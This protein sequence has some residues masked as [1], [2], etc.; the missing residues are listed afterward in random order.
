MLQRYLRKINMGIL[1]AYSSYA[2]YL[3]LCIRVG[4]Y[5]LFHPAIPPG[6]ENMEDME[7]ME[8]TENMEKMGNI[9]QMT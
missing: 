8:N 1:N 6:W 5:K 4:L 9:D 2:S 7:N 3:N